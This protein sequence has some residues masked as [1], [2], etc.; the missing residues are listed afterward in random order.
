MT[1]KIE[2][3]E[4]CKLQ[5]DVFRALANPYRVWMVEKLSLGEL[6]VC[7]FYEALELNYSTI[8]RHLSV[9][10]KAGIVDSRKSGKQVFYKLQA[11]CVLGFLGCL[12]NF[13]QK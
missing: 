2:D 4:L 3:L 12:N 8:S 13:I 5:A 1:S 6:C 7:E 11:H 9:L 10:K